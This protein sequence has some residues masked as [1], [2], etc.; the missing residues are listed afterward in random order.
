MGGSGRTQI[1]Q[2]SD[3]EVPV[4]CHH[5]LYRSAPAYAYLTTADASNLLL[6]F[7]TSFAEADH[8]MV[9]P[10]GGNRAHEPKGS[11]ARLTFEI[12]GWD[13]SERKITQLFGLILG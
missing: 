8:H 12:G 2:G 1:N 6:V 7:P 3:G 10:V 11:F 13:M 9:Q 5:S 4:H